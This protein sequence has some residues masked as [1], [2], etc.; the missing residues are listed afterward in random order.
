DQRPSPALASSPAAGSAFEAIRE[1]WRT[2]E[3]VNAAALRDAI[4]RFLSR[5]PSDGLVPLA[6]LYLALVAM[7]QE[8]FATAD[9]EIALTATL[10]P[11]TARDLWTIASARRLRLR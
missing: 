7:K 5:Y 4:E 2:P 1:A 6:R 10:P 11:G 8:D 9:R 3:H